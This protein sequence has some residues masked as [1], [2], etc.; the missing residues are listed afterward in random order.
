MVKIYANLAKAI[1]KIGMQKVAAYIAMRAG[2]AASGLAGGP[3]V[4]VT[5][6]LSVGWTVYDLYGFVNDLIKDMDGDGSTTPARDPNGAYR[7]DRSN[8]TTSGANPQTNPSA[9]QSPGSSTLTSPIAGRDALSPSSGYGMRKDPITGENKMHK[10]FDYPAAL[11]TP[12][13]AINDGEVI[14]VGD[15]DPGKKKQGLGKFVKLMHEDGTISVYG[16]MSEQS[17][18]KGKRIKKGDVIGKV[19]ST[20]R[21]TGP[22][23]H[24][25]ILKPNE[26]GV[27]TQTDPGKYFNNI[28]SNSNSKTSSVSGAENTAP[29]APGANGANSLGSAFASVF[30]FDPTKFGI[31]MSQFKG[32]GLENL[33]KIQ[34]QMNMALAAT[35][36]AAPSAP[37]NPA[38][39]AAPAKTTTSTVA[40]EKDYA[41][42]T[43][44]QGSGLV[45]TMHGFG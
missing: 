25:E 21:S 40:R 14:E 42:V 37:S 44:T 6:V 36:P 26:K 23:L 24:L 10:G 27:F 11:G 34:S 45:G 19:G 13:N 4:I 3:V 15:D 35:P 29:S 30:D 41:Y 33:Q 20:G 7:G 8:S 9:T 39:P 31:D 5:T 16:H 2:V 17:A 43:F 12:I 1:S 32:E 38:P 22:H 18:I 28:P